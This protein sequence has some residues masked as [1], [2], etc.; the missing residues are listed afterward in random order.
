MKEW[1]NLKENEKNLNQVSEKWICVTYEERKKK[2]LNILKHLD[3]N[4]R[5]LREI[6]GGNLRE[7]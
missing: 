2:I 1:E 6:F 7:T 5:G 4:L 3:E